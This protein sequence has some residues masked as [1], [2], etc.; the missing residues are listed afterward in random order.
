[1][2]CPFK[3]KLNFTCQI[4]DVTSNAVGQLYVDFLFGQ[5]SAT[6]PVIS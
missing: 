6:V 3:V 1:M 2:I 5:V 4:F